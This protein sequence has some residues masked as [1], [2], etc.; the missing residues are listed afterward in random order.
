MSV[1]GVRTD[2]EDQLE[3]VDERGRA[4]WRRRDR[5]VT[6]AIIV[7]GSYCVTEAYAG[8]LRL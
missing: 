8:D 7:T 2:I 5:Q 4:G 6:H 3:V 1:L